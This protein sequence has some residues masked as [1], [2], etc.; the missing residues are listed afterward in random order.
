MS[1]TA[2]ND[3]KYRFKPLEV[4]VPSE[5]YKVDEKELQK[6]IQKSKEIFARL[7]AKKR[8]NN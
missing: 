7:K 8:R 5:D 1:N 6:S 4:F 2:L 3:E